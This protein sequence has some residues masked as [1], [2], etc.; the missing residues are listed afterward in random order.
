[1]RLFL[2][3][4]GIILLA[5]CAA[6]VEEQPEEPPS[7]EPPTEEPPAETMTCEEY[8]PTQPHVECVG[9]WNISGTYPDC[10]CSYECEVEEVPEEPEEEP[11]E[12]PDL[13][14]LAQPSNKTL[15]QMLD[16]GLDKARMEFYSENDGSFQETKYTWKRSQGPEA[17]PGDITFEMAPINDV[18]F[19]GAGIE[20]IQAFGAIVFEEE[21]Y[22]KAYGV[23]IFLDK[24]TVLDG[25]T[26]TDA[27]DIEYFHSTEHRNMNDCWVHSKDL[28]KNT[29]DEWVS[30][31][32]IR[33]ETVFAET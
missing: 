15:D 16:D 25:Y 31:Y 14:D 19:D 4:A 26:G 24:M 23:V 29:E 20:S 30:T 21:D 17:K 3:L 1:M 7:A 27:F 28:S 13:D 33:C 5:G 11:E 6:P 22:T 12:E 18:K 8:C 10:V 9:T 2:I 32:F